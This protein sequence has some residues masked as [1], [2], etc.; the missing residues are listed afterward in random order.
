MSNK[1]LIN[2]TLVQGLQF[3]DSRLYDLLSDINKQL[4]ALP[5]IEYGVQQG[6]E[7]DTNGTLIFFSNKF[8]K[9]H[10]IAASINYVFTASQPRYAVTQFDYTAVNPTRFTFFVYDETG[11]RTSDAIYWMAIGE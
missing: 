11:T 3:K 10:F 5:L 4:A 2:Q 1:P 9:I 7:N 6:N 8:K